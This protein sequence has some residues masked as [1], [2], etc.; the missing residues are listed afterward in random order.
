LSVGPASSYEFSIYTAYPWYFWLFIV[1]AIV[2][3]QVIII[4]SAFTLSRKNY[5]FF[6]LGVILLANTL[7]LF[8]P[9]V[10]GYFIFGDGDVLTHIGYMKDILITSTIEGNH[11]PIDHI[12]GVIVQVCSGL[13]LNDITFIIPPIF[14]FFFI[15]TM[16]F[17]AK[18][19]FENK[20]E[21][22]IFLVLT[23]ILMLGE[24]HLAFTPN[25][26]ALL[27]VPLILYLAFKI[28]DGV[29]NLK[30]QNLLLLV[31][32]LIV[33]YHPLVTI[34]IVFI[35]CIMQF[36]QFIQEKYEHKI[37]KKINYIYT[38]V[39][40]LTVFAFWS[41]YIIMAID[42]AIP[43][44]SRIF[45]DV[46]IGS[47]LQKNV[48]L[49]SQ[50]QSD[51]LYFINLIFNI[52]G[53]WILLSILS[54]FCIVQILKSLKNQKT[55]SRFYKG[56]L[57]LGFF[58]CVILAI[59][60]FLTIDRFGFARIFSFAAIFSILLIPS[61]VYLFLYSNSH[62]KSLSGKKIISLLGVIVVI[63]CVTYFSIF[64]LYYSPTIKLPNVQ[65]PKSDYV[66]MSTFFSY[67]DESL[68]VLEVGLFSFRYDHVLYGASSQRLKIPY[69]NYNNL[70]PPDHFGYD[71]ETQSQILH[72]T[73]KYIL[74]NDHGREF[75][76]NIYPEFPDKWRFLR[77]DFER[78]KTDN[79]IQQIYSNSDLDI[80]LIA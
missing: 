43:L 26:Q 58:I 1:S 74:L 45:G 22:S 40:I 23:S 5:C 3:G 7:L 33:F 52:Y 38:I 20:F 36:M 34:M 6:G 71:N 30:Y 54:F 21:L 51:P 47:E 75:Y 24:F 60:M 63:F 27:F 19:I 79:T 77:G 9:P 28:Y 68:P 70:I 13:P 41:S 80:F 2:C 37:L 61:G 78:L 14:S 64:N 10:R 4:G 48:N 66:G 73:S 32:F 55:K 59:V 29:N 12:L 16:Y 56:V 62:E 39:F 57:V 31:G 50:V 44:I 72:D 76:P 65:V 25:S 18:T 67:R 11:Y 17:V 69:N 35:L 42:V 53:H 46:R 8:M 49:F 15:L